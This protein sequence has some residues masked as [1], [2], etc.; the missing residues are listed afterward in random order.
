MPRIALVPVPK[1]FIQKAPATDIAPRISCPGDFADDKRIFA[2]YAH[3]ICGIKLTDGNGGIEIVKNAALPAESYKIASNGAIRIETADSYGLRYAF[4]TLLQILAQTGLSVPSLEIDDKPDSEYRGLMVDLARRKHTAA[5][6]LTYIDFCYLLKL[7]RL[8]LHFS[9]DQSYTLPSRAFPGLPSKDR[10]F[11]FKEIDA[12]KKHARQRG[13]ILVPEVDMPGHGEALIRALPVFA[14]ENYTGERAENTLC[15]G[16]RESF[17]TMKRLLAEVAEMF[18]DSP[19]IHV[20]GDEVCFSPW[21]SC[22]KCRAYMKENGISDV[23]KLYTHTVKRLTDA[24]LE[25]NRIPIVWEGFPEDGS[26]EISKETIVI[27]WESYYQTADRL[28]ANGFKIINCSWQPLYIVEDKHWSTDDI[29]NWNIRNWQHWWEP[30]AAHKHP[31]QLSENA[32]V[33]GAQVC[34][35]EQAFDSE[36]KHAPAVLAAMSERTWNNSTIC[37]NKGMK[38]NAILGMMK[39]IVEKR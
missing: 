15:V 36:I 9:D 38:F 6:L 4:A 10:C 17:E 5:D 19:W 11:S 39:T 32:P 30:S 2:D 12:V 14:N 24:V 27:A 18:P 29:L 1:T 20:G 37:K 23:K 28:A 33:L 21:E 13:V 31:I 22:P 34:L 8:Q 26:E 3:K 35:W 7:N 25:L 16:K